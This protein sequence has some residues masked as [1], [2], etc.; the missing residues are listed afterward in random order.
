M[1]PDPRPPRFALLVEDN[2]RLR[3]WLSVLWLVVA[4]TFCLLSFQH[5]DPVLSRLMRTLPE[6]MWA[7]FQVITKLG[8]AKWYLVP[9]GLGALALVAA[10]L[11]VKDPMAAAWYRRLAWAAAFVLA[12]IVLAGL[13]TDLIKVLVGRA[14]PRMLVQIGFYGFAPINFR[15]DYQSFPSGHTTTA[16]AMS[17]AVGYLLPRLRWPL[18]VVAV[19][20]AA[21]RVIINAHYLSDVVGG[22]TVAL[23]CTWWLREGFT[24]C[25]LVFIRR[26]GG[27]YP[28]RPLSAPPL[29]PHP[30]SPPLP[31][32]LSAPPPGA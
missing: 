8:L 16:F 12:A 11:T 21:S 6:W 3:R 27:D 13:T 14:R 31:P 20:V 26:A 32:P 10:S 4:G 2:L 5:L 18:M 22:M 24:D 17:A 1:L 25:G 19:L 7:V 28:L 9:L 30:L 23:F 15:S 29:S